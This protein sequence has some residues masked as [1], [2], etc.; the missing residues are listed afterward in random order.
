[1]KRVVS[2]LAT[3]AILLAMVPGPAI[4]AA[5]SGGQPK[6]ECKTNPVTEGCTNT[7]EISDIEGEG[8]QCLGDTPGACIGVPNPDPLCQCRTKILNYPG[9][10]TIWGC[11]CSAKQGALP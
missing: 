10:P 2:L 6:Q 9:T 3:C 8:E 1:M 4:V 11:R 5:G 7:G